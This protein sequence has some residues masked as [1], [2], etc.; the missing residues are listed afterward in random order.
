MGDNL[1]EQSTP[2]GPCLSHRVP[3]ESVAYTAQNNMSSYALA[4]IDRHAPAE[5]ARPVRLWT[6]QKSKYSGNGLQL[7]MVHGPQRRDQY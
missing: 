6:G 1:V 4:F 3:S 2:A 7:T 5:F